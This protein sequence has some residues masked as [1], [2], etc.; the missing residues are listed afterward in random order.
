[1][2]GGCSSLSCP[3]PSTVQPRKTHLPTHRA[4]TQSFFR[5]SLL[6]RLNTTITNTTFASTRPEITGQDE[7]Y[8]LLI[9]LFKGEGLHNSRPPLHKIR[10][11]YQY[12]L[13]LISQ[14]SPFSEACSS[15][16]LHLMPS[17][18]F[19]KIWI[20]TPFQNIPPEAENHRPTQNKTCHSIQL[21]LASLWGIEGLTYGQPFWC[22]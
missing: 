9:F 21:N 4:F 13:S 3:L 12:I 10:F 22:L 19:S 6:G 20:S 18:L 1:M 7:G 17:L 2:T 11:S 15:D 5:T 14:Q 16:T 8:I